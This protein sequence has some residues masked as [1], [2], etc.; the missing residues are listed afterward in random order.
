MLS[1]AQPQEPVISATPPPVSSDIEVRIGQLTG[2]VAGMVAAGLQDQ[3]NGGLRPD[4]KLA[5]A[6]VLTQLILLRRATAG[7]VDDF[8][9]IARVQGFRTVRRLC[10]AD[11]GDAQI[12]FLIGGAPL[13]AEDWYALFRKGDRRAGA[14]R[15][16]GWHYERATPFEVL[17][18]ERL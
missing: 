12:D 6:E 17:C 15:S 18:A 16:L 3:Q 9:L 1:V 8:E 5:A 2:A 13:R 7:E 14:M 11:T 10:G 4:T